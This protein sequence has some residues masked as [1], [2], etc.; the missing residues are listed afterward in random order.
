MPRATV[1]VQQHHGGFRLT[2]PLWVVDHLKAEKGTVL[3]PSVW[4]RGQ[5][6]L[7]EADAVIFEVVD[8]QKGG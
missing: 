5:K 7:L 8:V 1:K 4:Y 2:L 3:Q 6:P